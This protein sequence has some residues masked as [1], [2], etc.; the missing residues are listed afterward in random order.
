MNEAY[1]SNLT[2]ALDNYDG[3]LV[4]SFL[5]E[6]IAKDDWRVSNKNIHINPIIIFGH[7]K[8]RFVIE[9]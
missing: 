8:H 7:Q 1:G 4:V 9:N 6:A 3:L 2:D 5:F